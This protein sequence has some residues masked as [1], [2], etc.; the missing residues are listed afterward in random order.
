MK[1]SEITD[2]VSK[3]IEERVSFFE[4]RLINQVRRC[5]SPIEQLIYIH[6]IDLEEEVY[7]SVIHMDE[8]NYSKLIPQYEISAKDNNYRLDFHLE[9]F[10]NDRVHRFAIEC[11]G[12]EFHE[13]TKEQARRDKKRDRDL[14]REG[15]VVMRFTGSEIW[16][17]PVKCVLEVRDIVNK[18]TGIDEYWESIVKRDMGRD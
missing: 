7:K 1:Y 3:E 15:Y 17:D 11:D 6:L 10:A 4:S 2:R 16:H 14:A 8:S 13:K 12:H 18:T 9:C 5:E